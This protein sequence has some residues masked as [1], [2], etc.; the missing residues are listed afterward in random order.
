MGRGWVFYKF[1]KTCVLCLY[2]AQIAGE[3]GGE[4]TSQSRDQNIEIEY[5]LG[6][7]VSLRTGKIDFFNT[8]VVPLRKISSAKYENNFMLV[9]FA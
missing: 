4:R 7:F 5:K 2:K 6:N 1:H 8:L 3:R 9:I